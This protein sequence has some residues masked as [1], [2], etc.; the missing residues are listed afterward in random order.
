[1]ISFLEFRFSYIF[2]L[3]LGYHGN[4]QWDKYLLETNSVYAP[5]DLFQVIKVHQIHSSIDVFD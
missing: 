3:F 5:R 4:F 1:M 2:F